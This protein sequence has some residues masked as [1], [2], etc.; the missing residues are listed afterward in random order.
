MITIEDDIV[1][2]NMR[3]AKEVES[4]FVINVENEYFLLKCKKLISKIHGSIRH[5]E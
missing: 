3:I 4:D 1:F 5:D 2:A